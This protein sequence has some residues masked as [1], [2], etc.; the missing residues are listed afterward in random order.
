M[1]STN[2]T[3][4]SQPIVLC[5]VVRFAHCTRQQEALYRR[6]GL[7]PVGAQRKLTLDYAL[8]RAL[9]RGETP[10][11]IDFLKAGGCRFVSKNNL[12]IDKIAIL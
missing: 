9:L 8:T 5:V 11:C 7:L 6:T 10:V 1:V 4:N 3:Y 2:F 12:H